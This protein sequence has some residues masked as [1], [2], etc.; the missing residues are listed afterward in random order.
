MPPCDSSLRS[1]HAFKID[2]IPSVAGRRQCHITDKLCCTGAMRPVNATSCSALPDEVKM[3][4]LSAARAIYFTSITDRTRCLLVLSPRPHFANVSSHSCSPTPLSGSCVIPG[5]C[6][7]QSR[8]MRSRA[9]MRFFI[10]SN[11]CSPFS[12]SSFLKLGSPAVCLI[13]RH[14]GEAQFL[15]T[16]TVDGYINISFLPQARF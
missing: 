10:P 15:G 9:F 14:T 3:S 2:S 1:G 16:A 5:I 7:Y 6:L 4:S 12:C 11:S 8:S 13:S